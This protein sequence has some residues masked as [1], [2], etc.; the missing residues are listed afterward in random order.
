MTASGVAGSRRM[1][2]IV[3]T[4]L[5][6]MVWTGVHSMVWMLSLRWAGVQTCTRV[7][8]TLCFWRQVV[9]APSCC[10]PKLPKLSQPAVVAVRSCCGPKLLRP[11]KPGFAMSAYCQRCSGRTFPSSS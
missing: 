4:L 5:W 6:M 2:C 7:C 3:W 8:Y 11:E 10:G 9:A 1:R